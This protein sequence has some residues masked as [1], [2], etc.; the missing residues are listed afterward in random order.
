MG[1]YVI[2][3]TTLKDIG[4][5]IRG[6]TGKTDLIAPAAMPAEIAGI[7]GGGGGILA[8]IIAREL[9]ELSNSDVEKIGYSAL[10]NYPGLVSVDFPNVKV[11]DIEALFYC[12]ELTTVDFPAAESIG[13][14]AFFGCIAL[15]TADFPVAAYIGEMAFLRDGELKSLILRNPNAVC[16]LSNKDAFDG[17]SIS[18]K[19]GYIYVP[20]ALIEDYKVATNWSTYATQFRALESY[21]VDGTITGKLDETKI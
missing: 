14:A 4:N 17:S 3:E 9:T 20:S 12:E 7:E 10:A 21:T 13:E 19:T 11:I 6:R 15:T 2:D 18:N 1:K 8:G 5:A 16:T